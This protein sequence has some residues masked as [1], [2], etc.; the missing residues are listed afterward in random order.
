MLKEPPFHPFSSVSSKLSR[1]WI[2]ALWFYAKLVN[3]CVSFCLRLFYYGLWCDWMRVCHASTDQ[4]SKKSY[5]FNLILFFHHINISFR[6]YISRRLSEPY[7]H[8]WWNELK[9]KGSKKTR[10]RFKT[11]IDSNPGDP[12]GFVIVR[13]ACQKG[14]STNLLAKKHD[15]SRQRLQ[16][17]KMQLW[18]WASQECVCVCVVCVTWT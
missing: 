1:T 11:K 2:P 12:V 9:K 4:S 7:K 15:K 5:M 17:L 3:E 8:A 13:T 14:T 18:L 16:S 6:V 10:H